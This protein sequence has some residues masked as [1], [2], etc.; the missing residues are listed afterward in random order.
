MRNRSS[1]R[2]RILRRLEEREGRWVPLYEILPLAAQYGARL[3]ELR[4]M[5]YRIEN[6]VERCNGVVRSWFRLVA[7]QV[8]PELFAEEREIL[9]GRP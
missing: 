8:Q 5:G 3:F 7:P 1:Q 4:R 9:V 2:D 6:R